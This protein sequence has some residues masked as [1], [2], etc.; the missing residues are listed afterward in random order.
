M[1]LEWQCARHLGVGHLRGQVRE[2]LLP[3]HDLVFFETALWGGP[4]NRLVPWIAVC[5][6]HAICSLSYPTGLLIDHSIGIGR[7]LR[8]GR[9]LSVVAEVVL[10]CENSNLR[11]DWRHFALLWLLL[12]LLQLLHGVVFIWLGH[13]SWFWLL[14]L[15]PLRFI[16]NMIILLFLLFWWTQVYVTAVEGAIFVIIIG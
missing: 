11:R 16:A 6:S 8:Y 1:Q 5:L 7:V 4:A 12:V 2:H 10:C 3:Y 15:L 13:W 9:A 14:F